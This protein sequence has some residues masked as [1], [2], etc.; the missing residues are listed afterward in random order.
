MSFEIKKRAQNVT[1]G[2]VPPALYRTGGLAF[3]GNAFLLNDKFRF[4]YHRLIHRYIWKDSAILR[5]QQ[6]DFLKLIGSLK[7]KGL[8]GKFSFINDDY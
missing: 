5:M 1:L 6:G 8:I 7:H 4:L 2:C 3:D